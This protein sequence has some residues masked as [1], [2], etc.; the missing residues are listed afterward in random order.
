MTA[1]KNFHHCP[2]PGYGQSMHALAKDIYKIYFNSI[3]PF[4]MSFLQIL[5]HN[6]VCFSNF[7]VSY[8][9]LTNF[10]LRNFITVKT[11]CEEYKQCMEPGV[12]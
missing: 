4:K 10:I 2:Y 9:R 3:P 5:G 1:F 12:A 7:F 6:F 11:F 8:R